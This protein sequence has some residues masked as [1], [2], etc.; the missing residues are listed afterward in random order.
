M[1]FFFL[2]GKFRKFD[3]GV[4]G[5]M[6]KYGQKQPPDYNL[7]NVTVSVDLYYGTNNIV[8]APQVVIVDIAN[9]QLVMNFSTFSSFSVNDFTGHSGIVRKITQWSKISDISR[10]LRSLISDTLISCEETM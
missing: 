4:A 3:Y 2:T 6:K 8:S 9:L 7:C 10:H 1:R 5:N